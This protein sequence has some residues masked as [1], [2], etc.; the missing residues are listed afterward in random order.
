MCAVF[1]VSSVTEFARDTCVDESSAYP[2]ACS[3]LLMVIGNVAHSRLLDAAALWM[4]CNPRSGTAIQSRIKRN[5]DALQIQISH[6]E[7]PRCWK[8]DS[9]HRWGTGLRCDDLNQA[10]DAAQ[11]LL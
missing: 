6:A 4:G 7:K 2:F 8:I 5:D 3:E 1:C 11:D 10:A 9:S